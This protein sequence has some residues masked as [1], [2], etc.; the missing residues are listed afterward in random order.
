MY[1]YRDD[2]A[3]GNGQ[4]AGA[5]M[6]QEADTAARHYTVAATETKKDSAANSVVEVAVGNITTLVECSPCYLTIF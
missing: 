1:S 5:G 6:E 2:G 3:Q 4:A